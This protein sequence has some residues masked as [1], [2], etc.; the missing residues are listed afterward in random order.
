MA[1][2]MISAGSSYHWVRRIE[3]STHG[4]G[5]LKLVLHGDDDA[6]D[7]CFNQA[8]VLIFT[9]NIDMTDRLV[10]AINGAAVNPIASELP[11]SDP[12]IAS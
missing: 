8:E 6:N 5:V 3:A 12:E 1:G 10:S 4:S 11:S 2:Y 7:Q 9:D